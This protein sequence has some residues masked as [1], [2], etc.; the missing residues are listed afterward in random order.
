MMALGLPSAVEGPGAVPSTAFSAVF[1][2]EGPNAGPSAALGNIVILRTSR[3]SFAP[4]IVVNTQFISYLCACRGM[5]PDHPPLADIFDES[6]FALGE[7]APHFLLFKF[8]VKGRA[9]FIDHIWIQS[10]RCM[11]HLRSRMFRSFTTMQSLMKSH[12]EET[13]G[14]MKEI[15]S[16]TFPL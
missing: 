13:K 15:F 5:V 2:V 7:N 12:L 14:G 1:D 8:G 10:S 3:C 11:N 4:P 6:V 9:S 16:C